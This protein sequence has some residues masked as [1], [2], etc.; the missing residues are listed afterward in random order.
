MASAVEAPVGVRGQAEDQGITGHH[1]CMVL[2]SLYPADPRVRRQAKAAVAGGHTVDIICMREPGQPR[3]ETLGGVRV[4]RLPVQ[5]LPG[6]GLARTLCEYLTFA[7]LATLVLIPPAVRRRYHVVHVNNPPD[8]LIVAGLLPRLFGSRLI[9]DI[10]DLSS[11]MFRSRFSGRVARFAS[12]LLDR[13]E[14]WAT[15]VAHVVV[16]VHEPYRRE[17][18]A[19]GV[20]PEKLM[21]VMNVIDPEERR[22]TQHR[23]ARRRVTA[24]RFTVAYAGTIAPWYGVELLIDAMALLNSELSDARALIFGGGDALDAVRARAEAKGVT[25]RVEFS[26][27]WLQSA[28]LLQQLGRASCGVVPNLPTEL[29]RF[30]L[31]T[32][33]F[34]YIELG[35]PAVVAR[36]ETLEAHFSDDEVTFFEPGDAASL[37][38]ALRWVAACRGEAE[39]KA[40]R[41]RARVGREYS[42]AANSARYLAAI[43]GD[44][45]P[46]R[47]VGARASGR[48]VADRDGQRRPP[49]ELR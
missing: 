45:L 10:H 32:K 18:I 41:A 44:R 14:L 7:T 16:T 36:L 2:H 30:A 21:V 4:R 40:Q 9:L 34:E 42:W 12:R 33:L 24:D 39:A 35:L 3:S 8:F 26:G 19:H 37:A 6:A 17:L 11:H 20:R 1:I 29:N 49:A 5:H 22:P 46:Y 27:R 28:E 31:S 47:Y 13:V 23:Y 43:T 15:R 25:S 48:L 38:A